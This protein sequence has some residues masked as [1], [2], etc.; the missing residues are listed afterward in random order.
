MSFE[1]TLRTLAVPADLVE[2]LFAQLLADHGED[3]PDGRLI[4]RT[5]GGHWDDGDHTRI[6]AATF[7]TTIK[8]TTLT[9]GRVAF[10]ALWQ[11]DLAAEFDAGA[12]PEVEELTQEQLEGLL[13]EVVEP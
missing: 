2:P 9:D 10:T 3:L 12:F 6:R 8:G 13:P 1:T 11:S 5:I 7:P 4:V